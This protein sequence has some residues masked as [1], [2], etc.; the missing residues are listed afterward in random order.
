M[1]GC[2][3]DRRR[4]A[5]RPRARGGGRPGRTRARW[6]RHARRRARRRNDRG[7]P[8]VTR[9]NACTFARVTATVAIAVGTVLAVRSAVRTE[10]AALV[11]ALAVVKIA[12]AVCGGYVVVVGLLDALAR[13]TGSVTTQRALRVP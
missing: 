11:A 9:S 4:R 13:S 12:V 8:A 3:R 1:A 10:E 7:D 2:R 5:G 6:L